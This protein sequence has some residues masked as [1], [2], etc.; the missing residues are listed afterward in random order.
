MCKMNQFDIIICKPGKRTGT[1]YMKEVYGG[2]KD[3]L[4]NTSRAAQTRSWR[5]RQLAAN[6]TIG[7]EATLSR[8]GR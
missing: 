7:H 2:S 8:E 3:K 4:D 6:S 1:F 5:L